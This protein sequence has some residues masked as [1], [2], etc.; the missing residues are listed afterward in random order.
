MD[1]YEYQIPLFSPNYSNSWIVRIIRPNTDV[2]IEVE[3]ERDVVVVVEV[4]DIVVLVAVVV[5]VEVEVE[6]EAVVPDVGTHFLIN[7]LQILPSSHLY[8]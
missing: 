6:V 7:L 4:A 8:L 3:V 5:V 1:K 2:D